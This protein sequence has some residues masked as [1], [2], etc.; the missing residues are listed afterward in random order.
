MESAQAR[1][2]GSSPS[3]F[4]LRKF[5]DSDLVLLLN[6]MVDTKTPRSRVQIEPVNYF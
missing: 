1:D 4:D 2:P 3:S 5:D 6:P